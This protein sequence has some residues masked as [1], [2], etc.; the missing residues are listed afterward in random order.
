[1]PMPKQDAKF[2]AIRVGNTTTVAI[3]TCIGK[4]GFF[5]MLFKKSLTF[6]FWFRQRTRKGAAR[7]RARK[8]DGWSRNRKPPDKK[9]E[10]NADRTSTI[11]VRKV[12]PTFNIPL[13]SNVV[14]KKCKFSF[15]FPV[16]IAWQCR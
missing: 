11:V 2:D 5:V 3:R 15:I 10:M 4:M 16:I 6:S 7:E 14:L 9:I 13:L 1:M 12:K 8:R